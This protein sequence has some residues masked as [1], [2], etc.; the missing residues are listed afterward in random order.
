MGRKTTLAV[1]IVGG[2]VTAL[3]PVRHAEPAYEVDQS[4]GGVTVNGRAVLTG[5]V[6]KPKPLPVHRDSAFCGK[7]MPHE[8]LQVDGSS[9]EVG[10]VVV[11]LEGI[12]KGKPREEQTVLFENRTCRFVPRVNA[13]AA[14]S[15]L[16]IS[17]ADPIMHNTHIRR[18]S[19]FGMTVVNVAQPPGSKEIRKSLHESGILDIR[20]DAHAFMS[21]SIHVFEHPYFAVTNENGRFE[22]THV[23]PGTY[24]LKVWHETLGVRERTVV[25][26]G[27]DSVTV[28]VELHPEE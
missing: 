20:C 27:K 13:V 26:P 19:R 14:G 16:V 15:I 6:P 22:L 7:T 3:L 28:D 24:R 25:V 2:I 1:L 21:A 23:P 18:D 8:G 11:S 5:A 4:I 17:N 10:G 9:R 12:A